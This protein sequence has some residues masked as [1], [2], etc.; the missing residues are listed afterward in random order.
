MGGVLTHTIIGIISGV[1]VFYFWR[2][3]EFF[4]ATLVGNT[5]VDFF[6]FF[7]SAVKQKTLTMFSITQDDTFWFWANLTNNPTNWFTFGFFIITLI[8]FLY[9]FHIIKKKKMEEYDEIMW[10]FLIGVSLHL[11]FDL[12]FFETNAWI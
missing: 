11:I 5:C 9:H 12:F 4:L 10:A 6:K 3:F 1:I 7:F 2:K 8:A